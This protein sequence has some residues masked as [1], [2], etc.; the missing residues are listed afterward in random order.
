MQFRSFH[1]GG[2]GESGGTAGGTVIDAE[3]IRKDG[4][5]DSS[6]D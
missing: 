3:F 6:T 4:E 5:P 2:S 1:T